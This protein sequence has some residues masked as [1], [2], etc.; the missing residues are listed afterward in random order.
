MNVPVLVHIAV[1]LELWLF[2][3]CGIYMVNIAGKCFL[4]VAVAANDIVSTKALR[5]RLKRGPNATKHKL[6]AFRGDQCRRLMTQCGSGAPA[7]HRP[8]YMWSLGYSDRSATVDHC[9]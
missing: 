1:P 6:V 5:G 8:P 2:V 7:N 4:L 9:S 3:G